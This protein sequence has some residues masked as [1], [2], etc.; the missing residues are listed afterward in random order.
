MK[1]RCDNCALSR[2]SKIGS[3]QIGKTRKWEDKIGLACNLNPPNQGLNGRRP[4]VQPDGICC[5]WT[6]P[7]T[8]AQPLAR[9]N[10]ATDNHAEI[11][12][13]TSGGVYGK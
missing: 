8:L 1:Q 3:V 5:K 13:Q 12:D 10:P 2:Q 4:Q 9:L 7:D 6:D 11:I